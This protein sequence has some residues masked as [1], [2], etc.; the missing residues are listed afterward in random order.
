MK[1]CW[2]LLILGILCLFPTSAKAASYG[3]ENY[4]I[5]ATVKENGD[6]FVQELFEM[7]GK[8]NGFDRIIEYRKTGLPSFNGTE[9]SFEGSDIY[10][11]NGINLAQVRGISKQTANDFSKLGTVGDLFK[12]TK[13][14]GS[15]DYGVYTE[16]L[17]STGATYRMY[18]PSS[19]NNYFY[20]E[21]TLKN[22]GIV[23]QDVAEIGWNIFSDQLTESVKHLELTIEIPNNK[24]DL[25]AWAHGPLIGNIAIHGK[26]QI[27]VTI[28]GLEARSAFDVRFLFDRS[29][30]SKSTKTTS[31]TAEPLILSVEKK[32]ADQAEEERAYAQELVDQQNIRDI[33]FS[34][35]L[36][37]G[38]AGL[39]GYTVYVG[40][41][42]DKEYKSAFQNKYFRDFPSKREPAIVGYLIRKQVNQDD[43]SASILNLIT[44]KVVQFEEL[45][46][47]DY[48]LIKTD[49]SKWQITLSKHDENLLDFLFDEKEEV[50]LSEL[51]KK[52]KSSYSTFI[53]KYDIWNR[54]I[55]TEAKNE[56]FFENQK[57]TRSFGILY[58]VALFGIAIV[59]FVFGTV[60]DYRYVV[61]PAGWSIFIRILVFIVTLIILFYFASFTRRT[62]EANE[63]YQ[64]WMALKRF[65]ED[66]G[67]MDEKELPQVALWDQYLVYALTLGCAEQLSK[68]MK[69]KIQELYPGGYDMM[70]AMFDL[71]Y[72]NMMMSFNRTLHTSMNSAMSSAYSAQTTANSSH[73]S[74]GGFGGGFSSGGGS[75]GGGG[76]GGRF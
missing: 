25:R 66:F 62:K 42:K 8:Y 3:I 39:I 75:F 18:Q 27:Q 13:G 68:Q 6:I 16:S 12:K 51:K 30:L 44:K 69:L 33:A 40:I 48:K 31:A 53:Q 67:R 38:L 32:R 47:K 34:V 61:E 9:S 10:N 58:G 21:Y 4:Y 28:D 76:G 36:L 24:T 73:S 35:V 5:H 55:L 70:D 65:M 63:E 72:M 52:A 19:K 71:H 23:H 45:P 22:M 7:N 37:L 59:S 54:T 11:G 74:S 2:I 17:T 14:A 57:K 26:N 46:K 41:K 60:S 1:K 64:K 49:P 29:A 56:P 43:L 15:G 20:L 50:L